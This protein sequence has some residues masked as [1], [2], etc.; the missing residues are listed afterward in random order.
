[1]YSFRVRAGEDASCLNLYQPRRPR[2]LGVPAKLI[3]EGGFAFASTNADTSEERAN[4]WLL[5][6][7]A[8]DAI[9]VMGEQNTVGWMIKSGL[10]KTV[11]VVGSQ[12]E[13]RSL[14]IDGLLHDSVFQ[15]GLLMSANRFLELY[16]RQE[17][18]TFFLIRT[19]PEQASE[20]KTL[21]E[22]ALAD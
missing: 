11:E 15:S 12:G 3:Q 4:P 14:R 7:R 16:P 5:L 17:G 20:V 9:P 22:T 10:G 19:P 18:F 8:G 21:L 2:L 1:V 13:N 6:D